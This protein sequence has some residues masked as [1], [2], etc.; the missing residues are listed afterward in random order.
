MDFVKVV[1]KVYYQ[2]GDNSDIAR[3]KISYFYDYLRTNYRINTT[4]PETELVAALQTR[5][6]AT[7]ETLQNLFASIAIV[8]HYA[9]VSDKQLIALNENMEEFYKQA[10]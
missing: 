1:A 2:Q 6:I 3:K 10:R 5:S 7:T 4:L 8:N 9:H